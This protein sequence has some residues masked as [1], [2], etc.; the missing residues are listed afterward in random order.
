[1]GKFNVFNIKN[2][3]LCRILLNFIEGIFKKII[4]SLVKVK[5]SIRKEKQNTKS[6]SIEFKK[7]TGNLKYIFLLLSNR[8]Q[9]RIV[10]LVEFFIFLKN[11]KQFF[12]IVSFVLFKTKEEKERFPD[13]TITFFRKE[14]FYFYLSQNK[15]RKSNFLND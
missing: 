7:K 4:I 5:K 1:L 6:I 10:K 14:E 9:S 8:K 11:M 3:L 13:E 12:F 15:N 2:S